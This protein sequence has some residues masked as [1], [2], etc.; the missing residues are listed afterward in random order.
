MTKNARS[1]LDRTK[2][3]TWV[4]RSFETLALVSRVTDDRVS[5]ADALDVSL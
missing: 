2:L 5:A 4:Y 1:E 3:L